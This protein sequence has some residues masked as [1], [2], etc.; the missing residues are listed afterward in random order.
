M[1]T[2]NNLSPRAT[3]KNDYIGEIR[4]K[5]QDSAELYFY[6]DIVSSW[7]GAWDDTDQYPENIKKFLD[8]VKG[9]A[10]LDIY[11]N[12][13]GGSVFAGMAIY[14][15]LKRFDGHKRVY[16]DGLAAS[17]A[18]VIALSGDEI[19]I[20]ANSYF[21]VHKAWTG[22]YG[23]ADELRK[24][25]QTLDAIDEGILSVYR[26]NLKEGIDEKAI[27]DMVANETWLSGEEAEKY[28]R[29]TVTEA[30]DIAA[31]VSEHYKDYKNTP[32]PLT[33]SVK[34]IEK[35]KAL[36]DGIEIAKAKLLLNC[37]LI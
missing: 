36:A 33:N 5:K 25:S 18:S 7:W 35:S 21:M 20:P 2:I 27:I 6:G 11:I 24:M 37:E 1:K 4:N 10:N 9:V 17:I 26:E 15:M 28:F 31:S 34:D 3:P 8:E 19:I 12:S 22:V 13:G 29:I 14:N 30:K 23:N 16:V 32:K